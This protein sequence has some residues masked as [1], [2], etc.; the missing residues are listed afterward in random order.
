MKANFENIYANIGFLFY[1]IASEENRLSSAEY[2]TLKTIIAEKWQPERDSD[3]G[4]QLHFLA[5]MNNSVWVAFHNH[6]TAQKAFE[7]WENCFFVHN[8][9]IGGSL[10]QRI[11]E[12][13]RAIAHEFSISVNCHKPNI[14][15]DTVVLMNGELPALA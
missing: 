8:L 6:M 9:F 5:C 13:A 2:A 1:A 4:L 12:T 14:L 7:L 10:R 15:K 11:L 3:A